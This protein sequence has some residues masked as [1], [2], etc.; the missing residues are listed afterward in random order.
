MTQF[1]S[2]LR[3]VGLPALQRNLGRTVTYIDSDDTETELTAIVNEVT[4]VRE[5]SSY[6]LEYV[7]K[8]SVTIN[9]ADY[10]NPEE[11]HH[12]RIGDDTYYIESVEGDQNGGVARLMVRLQETGSIERSNRRLS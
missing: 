7:N 5:E 11:H 6:G 9:L 12:L 1:D 10:A 8:R 4:G 2:L 3:K